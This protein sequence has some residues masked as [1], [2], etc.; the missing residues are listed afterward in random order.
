MSLVFSLSLRKLNWSYASTT[1]SN[2]TLT[3]GQ[4][5]SSQSQFNERFAAHVGAD[6]EV[7]HL[8]NQLLTPDALKISGKN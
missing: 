7:A 4:Q 6:C 2:S 3:I 1:R 8:V 5:C